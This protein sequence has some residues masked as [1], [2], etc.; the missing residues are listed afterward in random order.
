MAFTVIASMTRIVIFP[1]V[2]T[3]TVGMIFAELV[4][5]YPDLDSSSSTVIVVFQCAGPASGSVT[6]C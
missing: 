2:C 1:A 5:F 6:T 3:Y 4:V